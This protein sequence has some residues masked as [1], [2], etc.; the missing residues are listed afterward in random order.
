M[1]CT[2][3]SSTASISFASPKSCEFG[4]TCTCTLP[5]SSF[6]ATSLNFS[7]PCPFGVASATTWLNFTTIGPCASAAPENASA[8]A[9]ASIAPM[10]RIF[11]LLFA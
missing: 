10:N 2:S 11:L 9:P 6:S 1:N 7:A 5:G 4:N 3:P 8:T